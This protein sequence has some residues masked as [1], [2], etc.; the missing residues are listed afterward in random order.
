MGWNSSEH[1]LYSDPAPRPW[2]VVQAPG[3]IPQVPLPLQPQDVVETRDSDHTLPHP[4]P[5]SPKSQARAPPEGPQVTLKWQVPSQH[6]PGYFTPPCLC[7]CCSS[8]PDYP[9]LPLFN[10]PV[11]IQP[12]GPHS[13]VVSSQKP[14][15]K[16]SFCAPPPEQSSVLASV[17]SDCK[18]AS[19]LRLRS[20]RE[21]P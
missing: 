10:W 13:C 11:Q 6:T 21:L 15:S 5:P 20:T 8:C 12:L 19:V 16:C 18:A 4:S 9:S 2:T 14:S 3:L 17:V 7:T 1:C